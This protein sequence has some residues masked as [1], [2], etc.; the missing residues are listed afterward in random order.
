MSQQLV[1]TSINCWPTPHVQS[2]VWATDRAGLSLLL[3]P[4]ATTSPRHDPWMETLFTHAADFPRPANYTP[5][6]P[7]WVERGLA[8]CFASRQAAVEGE[9]AATGIVLGAGKRVDV[10]LTKYQTTAPSAQRHDA[11]AFCAPLGA[12]DPQ[13][14]GAYDGASVHPFESIFVKT[15]RGI[16]PRLVENLSGWF[17]EMGY[18][19]YDQ[20]SAPAAG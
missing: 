8:Q 3:H 13:G 4:P 20:C 6:D 16:S 19:S 11:E 7:A 12:W 14:E 10:L 2:M 1:G 17:D 15:N 9:I 18:S 5:N